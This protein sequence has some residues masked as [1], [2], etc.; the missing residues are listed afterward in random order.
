MVGNTGLCLIL[1]LL[2]TL[3]PFVDGLIFKP[4]DITDKMTGVWHSEKADVT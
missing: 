4:M 3:N 1:A 2:H